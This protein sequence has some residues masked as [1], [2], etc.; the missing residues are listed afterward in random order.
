MNADEIEYMNAHG[1][2][3]HGVWAAL[4]PEGATVTF[5]TSSLFTTRAEVMSAKI[6]DYLRTTYTPAELKTKKI[7][8]VGCYDGWVLTKISNELKFARMVGVE[9]RQKNIDKGAFARKVCQATTNC[10]FIRGGYEDLE[11]LFPGEKFDIVLCLGMAHH[12]NSVEHLI[13]TVSAKCART[14]IV[15]SMIIPPLKDDYAEI[16]AVINPVDIIYRKKE[17]LWGLA[18][19][20]F[21]SP[22]FDG[23]T[24]DAH[25]VNIPQE[26]LIRMCLQAVRFSTIESLMTEKDFYPKDFQSLRGVSEVMLAASRDPDVTS[27]KGHWTEDALAYEALF[28]LHPTTKTFL[29]YLFENY[30]SKELAGH[31]GEVFG[32]ELPV[33][34]GGQRTYS[35]DAEEQEIAGTISRAPYE[36]TLLELA[37]Y[38]LANGKLDSARLLLRS[39]TMAKNA[40]WRSFYRACF[41]LFKLEE[42]MGDSIRAKHYANLLSI[43]NP[44]FPPIERPV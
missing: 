35:L 17:K 23:S 9:P 16:A 33:P 43:S 4:D 39:I 20:K 32:N 37:K 31:F 42:T 44:L 18:A 19:Y 13:R 27:S 15:D 2:Y 36:K 26:S 3:D 30:N 14:L 12:V 24:S 34:K 21:E 25:L 7:I 5:G 28:C 22:Y 40:D 8:D 41:L 11:D 6:I 10:E 1:P 29:S 38:Q